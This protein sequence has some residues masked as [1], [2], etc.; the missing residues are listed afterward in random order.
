MSKKTTKAKISSDGRAERRA[1]PKDVGLGCV[2]GAMLGAKRQLLKSLGLHNV[3]GRFDLVCKR[4]NSSLAR[5]GDL[6]EPYNEP[7]RILRQRRKMNQG[8]QGELGLGLPGDIDDDN[9]DNLNNP[10]NVNNQR[11]PNN[12]GVPPVT[13]ARPV[14]D[15]AVPLPANLAS[16][17]R[18]PP[19]EGGRSV[20]DKE[21]ETLADRYPLIE[22]ATFLCK[23]GPAFM[24]PL[25]DDKATA[26]EAM[27]DEEEDADV[28]DEANA[29]MVFGG[30]NDEA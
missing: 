15:V 23:S 6:V 18:K 20:T 7:E 21:M 26:D 30:D 16:S 2:W 14:R 10:K 9:E 5:K 22:S 3:C 19:P 24:E 8:R 1:T 29:L 27:D 25:D 4:N 11:N 17:I 28:A 13:P 12:Q